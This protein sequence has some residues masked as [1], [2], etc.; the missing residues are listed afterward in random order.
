MRALCW[1]GKGDIRCD[2]VPDWRG[3]RR[4]RRR[5]CRLPI[6]VLGGVAPT[7]S[8]KPR[9][10]RAGRVTGHPHPFPPLRIRS[11]TKNGDQGATLLL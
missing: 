11:L 7:A 8:T 10:T 9:R 5:W 4:L 6:A 2:S 3:Y 1:H